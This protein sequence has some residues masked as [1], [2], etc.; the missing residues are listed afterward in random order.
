MAFAALLASVLATSAGAEEVVAP[1]EAPGF[2]LTRPEIV[3]FVRRLVDRDRFPKTAVLATLAEARPRPE[4]VTAMTRPAEKT[5][6]WWEYRARFVTAG[7]VAAGAVFWKE[8][9]D[10]LDRAAARFGVAP[11]FLVAILGVET[12]Y[13][14]AA[15]TFRELDTLMTFAF[16]YP[17]REDYFRGELRQF[18]LLAREL[19]VDPLTVHGSYGG[20]LG[21]PQLMPSSYRHFLASAE[22]RRKAN[23]WS[24]WPFVFA[25]VAEFLTTRGWKTG[26]R[27]L[28]DVHTLG[29]RDVAVSGSIALNETAGALRRRGV[30]I[31]REVPD[32]APAVLIRAVLK[33]SVAYRVGLTNFRVISR[34]NPRINYAMAVCDLAGEIRAAHEA[35]SAP[36]V[37]A[38]EPAAAPA[39]TPKSP[40]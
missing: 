9:A 18:L 34:Y 28:V 16:D 11:E 3:A 1:A 19:G 39:P 20:A 27:A 23:L 33:E 12:N 38:P 21:A 40:G 14:Q 4:L 10:E 31:D 26:E 8:H 22:E 24:E 15:G 17:A 36:A 13:G 5:L 25:S 7:R 29:N 35:A 37:A 2:D 6:A 32:G 30:R